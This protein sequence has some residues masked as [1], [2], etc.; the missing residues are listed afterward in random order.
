VTDRRIALVTGGARGLGRAVAEDLHKRGA[1]VIATVRHAVD[2]RGIAT[3]ELDMRDGAAIDALAGR[4]ASDHARLDILVGNAGI[5]SPRATIAATQPIDWDEVIAVNLTANYRLIRAMD[6]LL[7][8]SPAGR[9]VFVSSGAAVAPGDRWGAYG[10]SKA[11]LNMLVA[12]WA[13][14]LAATNARANLLRPGP[15]RTAMRAAA[16]PD[17]DPATVPRPEHI[18]R[19]IADM[20][21]PGFTKNGE[22]I[23]YR[24]GEA[25]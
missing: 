11:A 14:E 24:K 15:I 1:A 4:I 6:P 2:L 23:R 10:V 22:V 12:T 19:F 25:P 17:E 21:E 18:A 9:A 20:C 16:V 8:A 3:A 7:R 5:L 13:A